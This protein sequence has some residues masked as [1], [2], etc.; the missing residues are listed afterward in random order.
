MSRYNRKKLHDVNLRGIL[1]TPHKSEDLQF[2]RVL[3]LSGELLFAVVL[4]LVCIARK[5]D[6][7]EGKLHAA[8]HGSVSH[9]SNGQDGN[10]G[11]CGYTATPACLLEGFNACQ[12]QFL[13]NPKV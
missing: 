9:G 5:L 3:S 2:L 13:R 6:Q 11:H 10:I 12:P 8:T 4:V 7:H 1:L